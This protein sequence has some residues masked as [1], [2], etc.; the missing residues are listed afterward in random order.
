[1]VEEIQFPE[2]VAVCLC[3]AQKSGRSLSWKIQESSKGIL[4]QLF[5]KAISPIAEARSQVFVEPKSFTRSWSKRPRRKTPSKHRRNQRCL[6]EFLH[7]KELLKSQARH[8]ASV[9][10]SGFPGR[11]H[12]SPTGIRSSENFDLKTCHSV[13]FEMVKDVPG[14]RYTVHE[15]DDENWIPR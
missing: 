3:M 5:W 4:V 13:V 6:Q 15:G 8:G 10:D 7:R 2:T 9:E 1:M 12:S 11:E 14:V